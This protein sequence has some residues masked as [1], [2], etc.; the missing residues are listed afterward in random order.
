MTLTKK[1]WTII[2]IV[3]AIILV[4]YFFLRKKS[5]SSESSY[6]AG[7]CWT[8]SAAEERQGRCKKCA[9]VNSA[10]SIAANV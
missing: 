2:G 3:V 5:G 10:G 7:K 1:H 6:V 9:G 4:W 8:C